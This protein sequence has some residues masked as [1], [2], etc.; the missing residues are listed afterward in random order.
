MS[1]ITSAPSAAPATHVDGPLRRVA[2]WSIRHRW[3]AILIWLVVVGGAVVAGSVTGMRTL[4][5]AQQ[6]SGESGRA[7]RVA[8]AAGFPAHITERVL[9]QAPP[10]RAGAIAAQVRS[11]MSGMPEVA[12]VGAPVVSRDGGSTVV[13]VTVAVGN[14]TGDA[15]LELAK[16]R[17]T[18][19]QAA[20]A[21]V[22]RANPDATVGQVGDASIQRALDNTFSGDFQ[23][24]ELLSIPV[25]LG[26]LL[27]AFGAL[28]AAGVPVLLAL[29]AVATAMG[30]AAVASQGMPLGESAGSVT[31]LI[32]MAVGVDYSLFYVR[33]AREERAAGAPARA[34]LDVAA[35]TSGRAVLV[36]GMAVAVAMG[37]LL[38]SG[39]GEFQGM[40]LATILVVAA[41]VTGSLTVLPAVLSLLGDRLDR[42]RIPLLHRLSGPGRRARFWPA[43]MRGVLAHPRASFAASA[44]AL[45]ALALPALGMHLGEAGAD[46]LPRSIPELRT[47]DRLTAAFPQNGFAHTVVL[48]SHDGAPLDRARVGAAVE[49]LRRAA[50]DTPGFTGTSAATLRVAPDGRTATIDLPVTG[51]YNGSTAESTLTALRT[52]LLPNVRSALPGVDVAVSGPTAGSRDFIGLMRARLPLVVGFVLALTLVMLTAAFRSVTVALTAVVLNLLS[53][54]AAYGLLTLVFQHGVGA[55]LVGAT[56]T[57][58]VV[59]WLP[60]FLFV[61]LFG[62]SMDYHVFVVSRIREAHESGLPT[63]MA[64]ARGVTASAGVVTSAAAVMVG[65]FSIFGVLSLIQFKQMGVGLA[66]AVLIDA[67]IVR[68]VL[69]PSAMALLGRRNWWLPARLARVLPAAH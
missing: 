48:W 14:A 12:S 27:V 39:Q 54:G 59:D 34:A 63:R 8:A 68:A 36:S 61:V 32:G 3:L 21:A 50:A 9:I 11:R 17:V 58:F 49:G 42:P 2:H 56:T 22:A 26:I 24:S 40:A 29:S 1:V 67:T 7:D 55:G 47:Y 41:A 13:P 52:R 15:A 33:R 66:A 28:F 46:S 65:V 45:L 64:I 16:R 51:D 4:S 31:M 10:G 37:G 18:A 23:R 57:G 60:L 62:L 25:T 69:L 53:V 5:S 43:A 30:M 38:L 44:L 19:V 20:T 6:G 35:S